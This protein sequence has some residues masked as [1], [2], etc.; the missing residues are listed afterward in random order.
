MESS[1]KY[2]SKAVIAFHSKNN[3]MPIY[4]TSIHNQQNKKG[5]ANALP[6]MIIGLYVL[7][8]VWQIINAH[9]YVKLSIVRHTHNN[10]RKNQ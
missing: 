5:N 9:A 10:Y 4:G 7:E 8:V 6:L 1:T 3:P 2:E